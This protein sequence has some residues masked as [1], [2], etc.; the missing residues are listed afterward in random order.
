MPWMLLEWFYLAQVGN[1]QRCG[2]NQW[3]SGLVHGEATTWKHGSDGP[4]GRPSTA[5]K[6]S[7][8]WKNTS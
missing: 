7:S 5:T 4:L 6:L 8:R 3:T 1:Q 2:V